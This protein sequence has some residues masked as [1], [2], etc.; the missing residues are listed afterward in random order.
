M[1]GAGLSSSWNSP[2]AEQLLRYTTLTII[3][4]GQTLMRHFHK[5]TDDKR[6]VVILSETLGRLCGSSPA[7]LLVTSMPENIGQDSYMAA[8]QYGLYQYGRL[9]CPS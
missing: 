7:K 3:A 4:T 6:M 1:C 2:Q 9:F 8:S 5:P